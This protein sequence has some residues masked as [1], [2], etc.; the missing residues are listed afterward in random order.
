MKKY[1][2]IIAVAANLLGCASLNT[3]DMKQGVAAK[4]PNTPK[5]PTKIHFL[6]GEA[7]TNK[8]TGRPPNGDKLIEF[9]RQN[10]TFENWTKLIGFRYQQL[11]GA[12][13][14]PSK[15]ALGMAMLLRAK[16]NPS[17]ISENKNNSEAMI[18]F[19]T[20]P[21]NGFMEFNI[22]RY[23]KSTDG[24]AVVSLQ[25]AYRFKDTSE[26]NINNI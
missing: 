21:Q 20:G 22:F 24:K 18:D 16:G 9:F 4:T 5:N 15:V 11:P 10:E 8:F 3:G 7:F 6:D 2:L 12:G 23:T 17:A 14:D 26:S 25:L 13:N 1:I 19:I